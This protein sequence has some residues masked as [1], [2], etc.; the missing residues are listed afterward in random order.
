MPKYVQQLRDHDR[1]PCIAVRASNWDFC[2]YV[3]RSKC[4]NNSSRNCIIGSTPASVVC[5]E[6]FLEPEN[7]KD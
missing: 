1:N 7:V 4:K 2:L 3:S 5:M 6:C